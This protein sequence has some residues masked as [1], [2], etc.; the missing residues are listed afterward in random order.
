MNQIFDD[1]VISVFTNLNGEVVIQVTDRASHQSFVELK[2]QPTKSD[3][4]I[5]DVLQV[6][7]T[8]ILSHL[9]AFG[10]KQEIK[11][12]VISVFNSFYDFTEND[13][14][15]AIFDLRSDPDVGVAGWEPMLCDFKD[16]SR[17]SGSG[18]PHGVSTVKVRFCRYV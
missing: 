4:M 5:P 9:D 2:I 10:K 16:Q 6:P 3:L 12:V 11:E 8:C 7:C 1:H 14:R 13:I 18:G 15:K 17:W